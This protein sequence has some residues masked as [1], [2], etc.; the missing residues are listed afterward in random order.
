MIDL[1]KN[2]N[3]SKKSVIESQKNKY[4]YPD[5]SLFTVIPLQ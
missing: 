5:E 3:L 2:L 4:D 1:P